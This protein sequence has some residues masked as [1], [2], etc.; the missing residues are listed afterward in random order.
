M[1]TFVFD[2]TLFAVLVEEYPDLPVAL[3]HAG[4]AS[5]MC[6]EEQWRGLA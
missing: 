3:L 5:F 1:T 2:T 4:A 6:S